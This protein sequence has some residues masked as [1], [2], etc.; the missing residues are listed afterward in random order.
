MRMR[1]PGNRPLLIASRTAVSAEPAPSVPISRSAVNPAIRSAR[2]ASMAIS[3]RCGTDSSTVCRS[4]AP[5]CRKQVDMRIDH[6][7]HQRHVA[8]VDRLGIGRRR[9]RN[10]ASTLHHHQAR[11]DQPPCPHIQHVRRAQHNG[12]RRLLCRCHERSPQKAVPPSEHFNMSC[13]IAHPAL[14]DPPAR[15]HPYELSKKQTE[16]GV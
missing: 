11:R 16:P 15:S 3:V 5:T 12:A 1:G 7:R 14:F 6:A 2:A 9:P 8:E 13:R 4:S 10:D